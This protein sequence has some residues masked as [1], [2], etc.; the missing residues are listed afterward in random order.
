MATSRSGFKSYSAVVA[1]RIVVSWDQ[2][3]LAVD[4]VNDL[5]DH[6]D[7]HWIGREGKAKLDREDC[8]ITVEGEYTWEKWTEKW[9]R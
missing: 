7:S 3:A 6:L 9:R 4:Q 1:L 8:R 2:R 5:Q